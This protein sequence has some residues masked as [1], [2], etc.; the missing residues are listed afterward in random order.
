MATAT[1]TRFSVPATLDV[2]YNPTTGEISIV[3]LQAELDTH[4][5]PGTEVA[6]K[7]RGR[8]SENPY[9]DAYRESMNDGESRTIENIDADD[10][11]AVRQYLY[12]AAK[13]FDM[14]VDILPDPTRREISFRARPKIERKRRK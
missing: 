11:P 2:T 5:E 12:Q 3:G 8:R 6:S 14:G 1:L 13:S 10:F 7:P 4:A 9:L